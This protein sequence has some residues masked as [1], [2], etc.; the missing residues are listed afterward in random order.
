MEEHVTLNEFYEE[1]S[2]VATRMS[3][4]SVKFPKKNDI[5]I[6]ALNQYSKV[7]VPFTTE[8][9]E[10]LTLRS[11]AIKVL[12]VL[13]K[14]E[15]EA[16]VLKR[17]APYDDIIEGINRDSTDF[18]NLATAIEVTDYLNNLENT[19]PDSDLYFPGFIN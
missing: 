16:E 3:S 14:F 6:E 13:I 10:N 7:V 9:L 1:L 15:P 18:T 17:S 11:G 19:T 2:T 5:V 12:D 4:V 8:E